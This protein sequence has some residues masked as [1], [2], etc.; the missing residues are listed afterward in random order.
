MEPKATVITDS[1]G[2]KWLVV[3][4]GREGLFAWYTDAN[5]PPQTSAA[6]FVT[7]M[8]AA[9]DSS[10]IWEHFNIADHHNQ[11]YHGTPLAFSDAT[12]SGE[13]PTPLRW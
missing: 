5:L 6:D 11:Y 8:D 1:T 9:T 7:D 2:K 13:I 3:V 4:G 12:V 10:I